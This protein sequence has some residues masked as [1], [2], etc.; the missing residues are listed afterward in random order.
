MIRGAL[1]DR[2]QSMVVLEI[3]N[4]DGRFET[5]EALLDTG[6]SGDLTLRADTISRLGLEYAD[7]IPVILGDGQEIEM[8]VYRGFAQWLGQVRTIDVIAADGQ[9]LFGMSLL[10]G[11]KITIRARPG[12]EVLIEEYGED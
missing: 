6:F 2:L 12:G 1:N 7:R 8:S 11:G 5:I 9:E 10:A 4:G 3:L